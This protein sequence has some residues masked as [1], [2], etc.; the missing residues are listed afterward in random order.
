LNVE[1]GA[2]GGSLHRQFHYDAYKKMVQARAARARASAAQQQ[3]NE[4]YL[5]GETAEPNRIIVQEFDGF[6]IQ[7]RTTQAGNKPS[8]VCDSCS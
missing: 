7:C 3:D 6:G 1:R 5:T 4:A 2:A 8:R